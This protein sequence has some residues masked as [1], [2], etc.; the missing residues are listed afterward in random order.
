MS[1][2]FFKALGS[3]AK[4]DPFL[5]GTI[6]GTVEAIAGCEE[7]EKKTLKLQ[8]DIDSLEEEIKFLKKQHQERNK[9]R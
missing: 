7:E 1:D 4:I 3:A 5:A 6:A 8:D 2:I 9:Q